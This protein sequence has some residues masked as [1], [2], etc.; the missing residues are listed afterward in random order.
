MLDRQQLDDWNARGFLLLRRRMSVE[1]VDALLRAAEAL[2]NRVDAGESIG[3]A[4]TVK[5]TALVAGDRPLS[6][7]LSKIFRVHRCDATFRTLGACAE[8][9]EPVADLL[10]PNVDCFLSQ[11][12]FKLPGALGQP[13]HQDAFYFP[14]DGPAAVGVWIAVTEATLA[15]GPLWILPGSHAEPVHRARKDPRERT[16]AGYVEIVDHDF[17]AAE[18]VLMQP[19]DVLLFHSHLMHKSTDNVSKGRRAA[20]VY[21][22]ADAATID[23]TAEK[24]G[25]PAPNVDWM[26]VLRDRR[27]VQPAN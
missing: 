23:R 27:A 20:M 5:E 3:D 21:H 22:Y 7:Q 4:Y 10:G 14:H 13:W 9:L 6:A 1:R 8:V 19:G 24:F 25:R 15:N 12:I 17:G 16:I 11:F 2:A 18:P 26:P